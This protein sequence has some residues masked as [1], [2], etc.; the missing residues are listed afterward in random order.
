MRSWFSGLTR[1]GEK[2]GSL[3]VLVA[4]MSCGMCFP[5]IASLAAAIGLGFLSQ[6]EGV[7]INTILPAFAVLSVLLHALG[8]LAH[9]QWLRTMI[10]MIG[11]I[12]LLLSIYPWFQYGWSTWVTYAALAWMVM[13]SIWDIWSPANKHCDDGECQVPSTNSK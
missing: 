8:W 2:V 12:V 6:F 10:G 3:G 7:M 9:R 5:A 4:L 1:V 11:P 13:F